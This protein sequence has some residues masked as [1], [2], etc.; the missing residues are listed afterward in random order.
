MV[1]RR[2]DVHRI[3]PGDCMDSA[4][5]RDFSRS[6]LHGSQYDHPSP[7]ETQQTVPTTVLLAEN[8]HFASKYWYKYW[9]FRTVLVPPSSEPFSL[10]MGNFSISSRLKRGFLQAADFGMESIFFVFAWSARLETSV[11]CWDMNVLLTREIVSRSGQAS[12]EHEIL[13]KDPISADLPR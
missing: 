6:G 9:L 8:L 5:R 2:L 13:L 3:M 7:C 11:C 10:E 12:V 4:D 1:T